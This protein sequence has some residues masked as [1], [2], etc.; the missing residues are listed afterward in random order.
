MAKSELDARQ[1]HRA[2]ERTREKGSS[3]DDRAIA[4]AASTSRSLSLGHGRR[5]VPVRLASSAWLDRHAAS[6]GLRD[7]VT[8]AGFWETR[9]RLA[10][11]GMAAGALVGSLLS[12]ELAAL[13]AVVGL[14]AGWL[15][16][17]RAV[18]RR[19]TQR[20]QEME[21]HL[22]EMLDV[23]AL[24]MRSGLSFDRSLLLY[25]QHFDTMLAQELFLAQQQWTHG[26]ARREDALR[27]VAASY[28][29]ALLR[30][31]IENM[32]RSLRFGSSLTESLEATSREARAGYR[33][34]KQ[35]QVAKA[36]VKMMVPT[37]A[38]I[39]PAMLILVLGPVLLE[40]M[41]GF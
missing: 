31:V 11:I 34:R 1:G 22:P 35:E 2:R 40:L 24:G 5:L 38:L 39:L 17:P 32:V 9:V 29:S 7:T 37:G 27:K 16:L 41:E 4:L 3:L 20:A 6:A 12:V 13:L 15:L 19:Q 10:A 26:L 28:D 30:R 36:P 21:R 8:A 18:R 14:C 33:A 23:L 25:T